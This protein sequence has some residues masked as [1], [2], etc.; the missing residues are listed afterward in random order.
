MC[1]SFMKNDFQNFVVSI[2]KLIILNLF[3]RYW[4]GR[5]EKKQFLLPDQQKELV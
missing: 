2:N 4:D 5:I 3:I 1:T